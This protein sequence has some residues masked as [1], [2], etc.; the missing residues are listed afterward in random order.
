MTLLK[1]IKK[2]SQNNQNTKKSRSYISM[3]QIKE[4]NYKGTMSCMVVSN[5]KFRKYTI[6]KN[7]KY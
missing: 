6:D 3:S 7:E 1:K 5:D 4:T 2:I